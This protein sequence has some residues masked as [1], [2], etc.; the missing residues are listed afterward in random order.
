MY[1]GVV[2][3]LILRVRIHLGKAGYA[4][5]GSPAH[6]RLIK[7]SLL[8][9]FHATTMKARRETG[10][11]DSARTDATTPSWTPPLEDVYAARDE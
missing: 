11:F 6:F 8:I 3:S 9:R 2:I 1:G 5:L 10:C 4:L 7:M